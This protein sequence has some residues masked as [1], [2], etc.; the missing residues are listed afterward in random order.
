MK[1]SLLQ[2]IK[3]VWS[4]PLEGVVWVGFSFVATVPEAIP[5]K[6]EPMNSSLASNTL[7]MRQLVIKVDVTQSVVVDISFHGEFLVGKHV[8]LCNEHP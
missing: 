2:S 4:L 5:E 8:P 3:W 1:I 6:L 7:Y